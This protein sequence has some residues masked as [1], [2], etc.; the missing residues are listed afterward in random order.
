MPKYYPRLCAMMFFQFGVYGLWL[1]I[2]GRFL[3]ASPATGGLGFTEGES[4]T[5]VG[6]AAAIGAI[7]APFIVQFADRRFAAQKFL[8]LLMIAGGGFKLITYFQSSFTAWLVLSIAF[9][10]LFMPCTALCNAISMRQDHF[11]FKP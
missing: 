6:F 3:T 8:G 1:P 9:T 10:V 4:G 7:C 2:A 11:G 5:I